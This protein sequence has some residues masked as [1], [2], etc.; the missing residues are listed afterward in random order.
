VQAFEGASAGLR[1]CHRVRTE[2]LA[3]PLHLKAAKILEAERAIAQALRALA[4]H[5][6][7]GL[8][9]GKE[10]RRDVRG[11]AHRGVVH[12]EIAPDRAND[13]RA[14]VDPHPHAEVDPVE[15][16]DVGGERP[17]ALLDRQGGPQRT[18][19]VILMGDRGAEER[20][21]PVAEELVD[22]ALVPMDGGEDDLER[23]IHDGV[24]SSAPFD[25]RILS[26]RCFG[27]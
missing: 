21:H 10:P 1:R 2:R 12:A 11:V 18:G 4:H 23:P 14:R 6:L 15:A 20:H 8:G 5:D 19:R 26:A 27:V 13:D 25:V 9:D 17:Q 3:L 22:G 16:L 7:P 24:P